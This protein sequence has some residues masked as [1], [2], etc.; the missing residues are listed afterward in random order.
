MR[1]QR[2][3]ILYGFSPTVV[4]K[5]ADWGERIHVTGYWF[6][7]RPSDWQP[8]ADVADFIRSGPP[9][10]YVGFGSMGNRD[11]REVTEIVLD[12]LD[13]CRQRGVILT[14]WGGLSRADLPDNVFGIESMPF[15][16]LFPRMSAVVHHGGAGTTSAGLRAGVPSVIVPFFADQPFWAERVCRLGVGPGPVHRKRLTAERLA[17]AISI[18][19]NDSRM[20]DRAGEIGERIRGEDGVAAAVHFIDRY[21]EAWPGHG[22]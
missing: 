18:A 21:L 19:V 6:L 8:P 3:P 13:R 1:R 2:Y 4:P 10:V 9:P 20:R 17:R 15:D 22:G 5:P 16:W 14:G 11:P 12:A 7:E